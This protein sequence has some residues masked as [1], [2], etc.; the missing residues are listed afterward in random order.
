MLTEVSQFQE[1]PLLI[2]DL[3]VCAIGIQEVILYTDM[4]KATSYFLLYK[5]Q[6]GWIYVEVFDVGSPYWVDI[7]GCPASMGIA[8]SRVGACELKILGRRN[9]D[10]KE[11]T[12]T[13]NRIRRAIQ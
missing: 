13:Q 7:C 8:C 2:V 10:T 1:V 11:N 3:S 4:F 12:E 9:K 5:V 6:C